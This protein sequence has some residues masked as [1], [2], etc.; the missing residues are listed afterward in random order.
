LQTKQGALEV[1]GH[2]NG[3]ADKNNVAVSPGKRDGFRDGIN[4]GQDIGKGVVAGVE[5]GLGKVLDKLPSHPS[6]NHSGDAEIKGA[7]DM[8]PKVCIF[9]NS[10]FPLDLC[11]YGHRSGVIWLWAAVLGLSLE[12]WD[13]L[14]TSILIIFLNPLLYS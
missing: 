11:G 12:F 2:D 7:N 10:S 3:N 6:V 13:F 5:K 4:E 1:K 8:E 9:S 14:H